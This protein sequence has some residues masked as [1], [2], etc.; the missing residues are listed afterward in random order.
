MADKKEP[1]VP[2]TDFSNKKVRMGEHKR[3]QDYGED[4]AT[5]Y[6]REIAK[7]PLLS[8]QREIDLGKSIRLGGRKINRL[9][10]KCL[11]AMKGI[12]SPN[13]ELVRDQISPGDFTGHKGE[14]PRSVIQKLEKS[15]QNSGSD[16]NGL[17]NLVAELRKTEADVKAAK[18]E[19]IQSNLR[20]VVSIAKAYVNGGLS[21][22]DLIQEGNLG[23]MKAV[24]RYDYRK[25]FKFST[26]ASWWI[27]Q[28]ITRA[29]T[30]KSKIVRIPV[31]LV[32]IKKKVEKASYQLNKELGR[33]P[34]AE[35][36]SKKAGVR[37]KDVLNVMDLM[38]EPVSL[39]TPVGKDGS[40]LEDFIGSE[41]SVIFNETLLENMDVA[42]KTESLLASLKP[43]EGEIVRLRF[44]IGEPESWTL[45]EI[46]KRWGI[47]RERVRQIE[48]KALKRLKTQSTA[49]VPRDV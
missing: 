27:R 9:T 8:K 18:A 33:D 38:E 41:E 16:A 4:I 44:G 6:L 5:I 29:L 24:T 21:L 12:D 17:R 14:I 23:L 34:L 47:S 26:Y 32:E 22:L 15:L 13:Q 45:D 43:R 3:L 37:P 1:K 25:G 2:M 36:I 40:R 49:T 11:D 31:H 20:L 39:E 10:L 42:K 46:G 35:E 28:A 19:M 48:M 7:V 30:D